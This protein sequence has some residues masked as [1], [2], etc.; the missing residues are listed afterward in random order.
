MTERV[1]RAGMWRRGEKKNGSQREGRGVCT[2]RATS[3]RLPLLLVDQF[4]FQVGSKMLGCE[5]GMEASLGEK[6]SNFYGSL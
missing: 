1:Q 2:G 3:I 5:V 6:G 4:C